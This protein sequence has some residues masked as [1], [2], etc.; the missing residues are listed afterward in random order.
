MSKVYIFY[1]R[2]IIRGKNMGGKIVTQNHNFRREIA[3]R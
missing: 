2:P 3:R 1:A